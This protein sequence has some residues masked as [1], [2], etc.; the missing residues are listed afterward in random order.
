MDGGLVDATLL[1]QIEA[2]G[3]A[4]ELGAPLALASAIAAGAGPPPGRTARRG[5]LEQG[6]TGH[7]AVAAFAARPG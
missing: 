4:G 1:E 3:Y 5:W 7:V 6:R 2:S